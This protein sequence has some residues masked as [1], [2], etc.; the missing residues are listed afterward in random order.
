MPSPAPRETRIGPPKLVPSLLSAPRVRGRQIQS[1]KSFQN[2]VNP[3]QESAGQQAKTPH[4]HQA[5]TRSNHRTQTKEHTKTSLTGDRYRATYQGHTLA[6][7]RNNWNKTLA[8]LIDG[9]EAATESRILPHNITLTAVLEHE[10]VRH[11]VI[12]RSEVRFPNAADTLEVDSEP[13]ALTK[14]R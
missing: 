10:G 2:P 9:Q 12:A 14:T 11:T 1:C 8:L 4:P 5:K 7:V 13:L 3:V 6:L